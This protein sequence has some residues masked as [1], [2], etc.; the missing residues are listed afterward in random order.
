[1]LAF[2][3]NA[4]ELALHSDCGHSGGCRT[5]EGVQHPVALLARGFEYALQKRQGL[6]CGVLTE[7]LFCAARRL[8][9]PDAFH[10]LTTVLRAHGAVIKIVARLGIFCRP[11]YRLC[12]VGEVAAGEIGRRIGLFPADMVQ[13]FHVQLLHGKA[14]GVDDMMRAR[15]PN[16]AVGLEQGLTAP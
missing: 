3:F 12:R 16:R 15:D 5:G 4:N 11:D 6:L 1:M 9:I 14:D 13:Q 10:L 8:D 2:Q 7:A